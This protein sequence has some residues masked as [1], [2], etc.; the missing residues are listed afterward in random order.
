MDKCCNVEFGIRAWLA[1]SLG[2]ITMLRMPAVR[3]LLGWA[4]LLFPAMLLAACGSTSAVVFGE[5]PIP[6]PTDIPMVPI[7]VLDDAG[8]PVPSAQ[9]LAGEESV[10]VDESGVGFIEWQGRPFNVSIEAPGFF[11]GAVAV[12]E[13]SD[14]PVPV[15]IHLLRLPGSN[16]ND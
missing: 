7:A 9:L 8:S 11:P 16:S 4:W 14:E 6:P 15:P 1:Q 5:S 3:R 13:F 10:P 2:A 12:S